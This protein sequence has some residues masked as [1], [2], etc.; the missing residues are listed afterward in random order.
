M[1]AQTLAREV[2]ADRI[3][4]NAVAPGAVRTPINKKAWDTD[5][6]LR[7]LLE[8]IP[9]AGSASPRTSRRQSPGLPRMRP[10]TSPAPPSLSI[11]A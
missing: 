6:V 3:R 1:L 8:L 11:A 9:M 7:K 5:E 4:V 10:I 2:V